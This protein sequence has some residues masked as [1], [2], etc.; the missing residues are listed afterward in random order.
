MPINPE[1]ALGVKQFEMPDPLAAYAK[2]ATI[3]DAQNRNALSQL[4][5]AKA[6]REEATTNALND[7]YRAAYNPETGEVD[8]NALSKSAVLSGNGSLISGIEKTRREAEQSKLTGQKLNTEVVSGKLGLLR[9]ALG[10]VDQNSPDAPQQMMSVFSSAF[11]D[12]VL[13]GYFTSYGGSPEKT[14]SQIANAVNSG[15]FSDLY[16]QSVLG[17]EKHL[18]NVTE[19]NKPSDLDRE[20]IA[21]GIDPKSP[22]G[23]QIAAAVLRK[24]T[25][26]A[27]TEADRP[28]ANVRDAL[29]YANATDEQRKAFNAMRGENAPSG[30]QR[31]A[32]GGLEFILGGPADPETIKKQAEARRNSE[33]KPLPE[34]AKRALLANI[35]N[36]RKARGALALSQGKNVGVLQGD[37]N[38]TG[39]KGFT[40]DFILQRAD[41]TGVDTRAAIA[42]L[43]SMIIHDRSGAAVTASEY[44]RLVPFI[45]RDRD[46]PPVVQKKLERF[47][48][49]YEAIQQDYA[50][51]YS[52]DQGYK[53]P[54]SLSASGPAVGTIED[55]HKF[56]GGDPADPKNWEKQ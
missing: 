49:E 6:K 38:A 31:T 34:P 39:F 36:L 52:E 33:L 4:E 25:Y 13:G 26:I 12:P 35:D 22:E 18:Q 2:M 20:M 48:Q 44:P 14:A 46:D 9:E 32:N 21:A 55:G 27:P 16:S 30:W 15:K 37:P 47:I 51:M 19:Q 45:P 43:G 29:W 54:K 53:L 41:P 40:P 24:K 10:S 28:S 23:R 42:D 50:D 11:K 7:A 5:F 3:K 8:Y 17:I 56:K 1:I